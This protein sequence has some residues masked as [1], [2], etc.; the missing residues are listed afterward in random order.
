VAF[1]DR[2]DM[3]QYIGLPC[4]AARYQILKGCILELI[5]VGLILPPRLWNGDIQDDLDSNVPLEDLINQEKK[6]EFPETTIK[7]NE[8]SN[9]LYKA[10]QLSDGF[11][12]RS[13]RRLPFQAHAFYVISSHPIHVHA[14]LEALCDAIQKEKNSLNKMRGGK[15]NTNNND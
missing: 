2:A 6:D 12:G 13:L 14:F 3:K 8:P 4:L 9:L 15:E 10:A 1:V 7:N 11:S 5:R